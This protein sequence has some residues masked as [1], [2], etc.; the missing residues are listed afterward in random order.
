[1]T[2]KCKIKEISQLKTQEDLENFKNQKD[3]FDA[4]DQ[5]S[6]DADVDKIEEEESG[7][8][9]DK[10]PEDGLYEF[11]SDEDFQLQEVGTI[12]ALTQLANERRRRRA[13][14][15]NLSVTERKF[16]DKNSIGKR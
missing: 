5:E 3:D 14:S 2:L 4:I 10:E 6:D 16:Y 8:G 9:E 13:E 12:E 15:R 7:E 11:E 1:M